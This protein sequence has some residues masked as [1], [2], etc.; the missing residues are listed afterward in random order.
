[1]VKPLMEVVTVVRFVTTRR[2]NDAQTR[3]TPKGSL[4]PWIRAL[5]SSRVKNIGCFQSNISWF[6]IRRK[7]YATSERSLTTYCIHFKLSL[8]PFGCSILP[9]YSRQNHIRFVKYQYCTDMSQLYVKSF[10]HLRSC[11]I[12]PFILFLRSI[13]C[14]NGKQLRS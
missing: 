12:Y 8:C 6:L 7:D 13:I 4:D 3:W 9:I 2:P 11:P 1:M 10:Y 5:G 14:L